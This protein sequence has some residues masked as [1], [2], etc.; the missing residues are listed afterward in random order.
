MPPDKESSH[1]AREILYIMP[2]GIASRIKSIVAK[3]G[4][5]L[6]TAYGCALT[7]RQAPGGAYVYS[8]INQTTGKKVELS[9]R[10]NRLARDAYAGMAGRIDA[11][12]IRGDAR[13]TT[14][15]PPGAKHDVGRLA[16]TAEHI[17]RDIL[18]MHGYAVRERQIELA[19]HILNVV[20]RRGITLAES[21]VGT[22]KTHAYLIASALAKRGRLNEF[23]M[24]GHYQGQS[25]A[26][27]VHMPVIISTSS[28]ALQQAIARDYIPELS[29]ILLEYG[30]I[31]TPLTSIIRKGKEH[32]ICEQ[33]LNR[34]FQ[35][36][37]EK[38]KM[39]LRPFIG[40]DAPFDLTDADKLT[41]YLKRRVCVSGACG[42]ECKYRNNC[43][44][45]RFLDIA[46]N[47]AIDFQITNH[48]Y[49]LA[50]VIHRTKGKK[51]LLPNYQLLVIDEAHKLL[52]AARQMYGAEFISGELAELAGD[53]EAFLPNKPDGKANI[54]R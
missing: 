30:I 22:G 29:K 14:D 39:L 36:T 46:A 1:H 42:W 50:D 6:F 8:A 51:P 25:W 38:I 7:E 44:Y 40:H 43:R 16:E 20:W 35:G 13:F 9:R 21:E 33:R 48:N 49:F 2:E 53:I 37:D 27:S 28:I 41:P 11:L 3:N 31:K 52:T 5:L 54:Y 32:Y 4:E 23:W 34:F 12:P 47:P 45:I 18:S 24:R 19:K 10:K 17:F 15:K 26:N